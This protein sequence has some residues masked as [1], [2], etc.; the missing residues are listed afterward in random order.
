VSTAGIISVISVSLLLRSAQC[1]FAKLHLVAT[2]AISCRRWHRWSSAV[3]SS[4][5]AND[6]LSHIFSNSPIAISIRIAN[7]SAFSR[8]PVWVYADAISCKYGSKW[9]VIIWTRKCYVLTLKNMEVTIWYDT[10]YLTC[11]KTRSSAVAE[12]PRRFVSLNINSLQVI[13]GHSQ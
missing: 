1:V 5:F 8:P 3:V 12:R 13:Q 10:V 7:A 4:Q 6:F 11:T 2:S 9:Q